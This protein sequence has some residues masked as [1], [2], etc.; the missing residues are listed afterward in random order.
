[1]PWQQLT[2]TCLQ[3][4]VDDVNAQCDLFGAVSITF[5]DHADS[6]VFGLTPG[7]QPLWP[8]VDLMA[9][10]EADVNMAPIID[11]FKQQD[12]VKNVVFETLED[13]DWERVSLDS[14]KPMQYSNHLWVCP[15]WCEPPDPGAIN[16]MIDPGLAFG[17]GTHET[18]SLCLSW[19]AEAGLRGKCLIDYGCGSG[20]LGLAALKLGAKTVWAVDN[21]PQALQA[22]QANHALNTDLV[23]DFHVVMPDDLPEIQADVLVANILAGPLV[24]L[25]PKLS[26]C[27]KKQSDTVLSG[28][29]AD[30][31]D[32]V[33]EEY[34][35]YQPFQAV[36]ES[37]GWILCHFKNK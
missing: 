30:Q 27:V 10:F 15:S 25:A 21:D 22:S 19:L 9:L 8:E 26:K 32:Q 29:L 31:A 35:K 16:V 23:G 18:T 12:S 24:E 17:T 14:F 36:R 34:N 3:A 6:P 11:Y 5:K 33:C 4:Q 1:M 37:S 20:I 13:Q 7:D 28:I 2:I